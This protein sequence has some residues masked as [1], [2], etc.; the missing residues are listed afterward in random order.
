MRTVVLAPSRLLPALGL[1]AI[2]HGAAA[3][4]FDAVRLFSPPQGDGSGN[5]GAVV[6][7]GRAY[8]GSDESRTLVVPALNYR[9]KNGWF[10]GT[11]NGVGYLFPSAEQFQYGVRL[12]PDLGRK[13]K[14]SSVLDGMDDV[15]LSA[16]AGAFFNMYLS[17]QFYL[18][19]SLRVGSGDD[20]RGVVL[21]LGANYAFQLAPQWRLSV[22]G[23]V[24][25]TD[26]S[27]MH[28]YFG[29]DASKATATRP[30]FDA[31]AGVRDVRASVSLAYA[32]TPF[33]DAVAAV[34]ASSYQGN[35]RRSPLTRDASPVSGILALTHDF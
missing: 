21:D 11:N 30:A 34:S 17:R 1:A 3:Q 13:A 4:G 23:A 15:P 16:E 6:V 19:S 31:G 9:W 28:S 2:A 12:T 20:H 18:T 33:C 27:Y 22:G 14:R 26:G 32:I 24:T 5:F 35:A 29:V 25:A 8:A 10:A 7:A